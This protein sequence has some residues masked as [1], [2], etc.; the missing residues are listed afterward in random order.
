MSRHPWTAAPSR[1]PRGGAGAVFGALL[2]LSALGGCGAPEPA[3]GEAAQLAIRVVADDDA[4]EAGAPAAGPGLGTQAAGIGL[5]PAALTF[6]ARCAG[7]GGNK[8]LELRSTGSSTLTLR[9]LSVSGA[10]FRLVSPPALPAQL[11]PGRSLQLTVRYAPRA[12]RPDDLQPAGSLII[13]SSAAGQPSVSVPLRGSVPP[14]QFSLS[15]STLSFGNMR[16]GQQ[17]MRTV[18]LRNNG[19]CAL[20]IGG[21]NLSGTLQEA[22]LIDD[23]DD[24]PLRAGERRSLDVI[25]L[26]DRRGTIDAYADF[27]T[28]YG[29]DLATLR[30]RGVCQP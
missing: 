8:V 21:Y 11:A 12:D 25:A 18:Q 2:T 5:S 14:L 23:P 30:V 1:R 20:Q 3:E 29:Q 26:C 17:V 27:F 10:A 15:S 22:V 9:T 16:V 4:A 28:N 24:A 6:G 19:A 13:N 7:T